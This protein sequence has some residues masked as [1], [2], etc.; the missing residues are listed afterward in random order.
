[1]NSLKHAFVGCQ[2]EHIAIRLKAGRAGQP[3]SLEAS[4]DGSGM[5]PARSG[6]RGSGLIKAL[7]AQFDTTVRQDAAPDTGGTHYRTNFPCQNTQ[8]PAG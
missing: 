5:R 8:A 3:C 1:M 7:G 4:D 2:L 6:S